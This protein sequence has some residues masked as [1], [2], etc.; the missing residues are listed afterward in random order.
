MTE[1]FTVGTNANLWNV[2]RQ[3]ES[4]GSDGILKT[5]VVQTFLHKQMRVRE[6]KKCLASV[7]GMSAET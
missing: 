5:H 2:S 7:T 1:T 4:T 3:I 6:L